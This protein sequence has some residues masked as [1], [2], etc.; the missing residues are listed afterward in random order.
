M[1][2]PYE[3]DYLYE[4]RPEMSLEERIKYWKEANEIF[5]GPQRDMKNFPPLELPERLEKEYNFMVIPTAWFKPIYER[6][7]VSGL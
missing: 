5:Y 6:L 3:E 4:N 7:G 2:H 1:K